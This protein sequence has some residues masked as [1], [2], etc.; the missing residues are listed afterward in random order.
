MCIYVSYVCRHSSLFVL[1]IAH[2][3]LV[4]TLYWVASLKLSGLGVAV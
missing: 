4:S 1:R 2:S 3:S